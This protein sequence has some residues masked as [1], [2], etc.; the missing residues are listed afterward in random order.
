MPHFDVTLVGQ[1]AIRNSME[2]DALPDRIGALASVL[3]KR[4]VAPS[5][6]ALWRFIDKEG[7]RPHLDCDPELED[8][9]PRIERDE[10][11]DDALDCSGYDLRVDEDGN[12]VWHGRLYDRCR[13]Q[14]DWMS[15]IRKA[16]Q[17]IEKNAYK[18]PAV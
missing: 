1:T 9:T 18:S 4:V 7:L 14:D 15:L 10:M 13:W 6:E 12:V 8:R 16:D 5:L 11:S 3:T 17:F 2:A